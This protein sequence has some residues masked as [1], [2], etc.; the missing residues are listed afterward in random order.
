MEFSRL[1]RE[2]HSVRKF[3]EEPVS[4]EQLLRLLEETRLAPT[5]VNH[6]PQRYLVITEK[7]GMEKLSR[8]TKYTFGAPC[9]I[10]V[11]CNRDE[12]WVN[13]Y[14]GEMKGE[15][16][17]AIAATTSC[18][19]YTTQALAPAGWEASTRRRSQRNS[20]FRKTSSL[21]PYSPSGTS[22]RTPS[23]QRSTLRGRAS[24]R[25][26]SGNTSSQ[27][28]KHAKTKGDS[29]RTMSLRESPF[30]AFWKSPSL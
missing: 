24:T 17:A 28:Q 6:Q 22:P 26:L 1:V 10:V 11:C 7:A 21:L 14:T 18:L 5:A 16:D 4:K 30:Y 9:A 2:R 8:C 15:V 12:A 23:P 20:A 27:A 3:T 29:R 13:R 25:S 19:P